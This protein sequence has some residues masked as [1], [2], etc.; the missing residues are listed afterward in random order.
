MAFCV[1][2]GKKVHNVSTVSLYAPVPVNL[3]HREKQ[4]AVIGSIGHS[5]RAFTALQ[6]SGF[7]RF[8][9]SPFQILVI[10]RP[11]SQ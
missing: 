1:A 5:R 6:G 9:I 11:N 4:F 3:N 8:E 7:Q 2:I 10:A